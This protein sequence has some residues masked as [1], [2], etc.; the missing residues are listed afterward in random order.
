MS[1]RARRRFS[2]EFKAETVR[3]FET[4]DKTMAAIARDL[5]VSISAVRS[6]VKQARIDNGQGQGEITTKERE[7]LTRLRREIR[8]LKMEREILKK[9]TAFVCHERGA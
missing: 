1:K 5:D 9:A 4:S 6:W 7:E 2:T 8:V 3:L